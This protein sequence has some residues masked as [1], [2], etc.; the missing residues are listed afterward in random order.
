MNERKVVI[1]VYSLL[2]KMKTV[3]LGKTLLSVK[4]L[5]FKIHVIQVVLKSEISFKAVDTIKDY[6]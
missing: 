5:A 1:F 2:E 6:I 4:V 3:K